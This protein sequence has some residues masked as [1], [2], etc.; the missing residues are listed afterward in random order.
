MWLFLI[1]W[2]LAVYGA[3]SIAAQKHR[4]VLFWGLL[5]TVGW[6]I[7]ALILLCL[8]ELEDPR[9]AWLQANYR[10]CPHCLSVIPRA[11]KVCAACTR[12]VAPAWMYET[13][14]VRVSD[15]GPLLAPLPDEPKSAAQ[16]SSSRMSGELRHIE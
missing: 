9:A 7:P 11:A 10:V 13:Q 3:A 14:R 1:V 4:S 6:V 16:P 15:L 5:A 2:A 12:D 8:P